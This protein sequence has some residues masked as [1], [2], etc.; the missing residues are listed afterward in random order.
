MV[1]SSHSMKI[2][3]IHRWARICTTTLVSSRLLCYI[4]L[5][6]FSIQCMLSNLP[7]YLMFVCFPLAPC[8]DNPFQFLCAEI[9]QL[10]DMPV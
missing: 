5:L 3:P 7:L 2:D 1:S 10:P 8:T 6:S 9:S 4:A